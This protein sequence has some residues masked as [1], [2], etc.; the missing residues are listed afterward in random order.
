LNN[1]ENNSAC[2]YWEQIDIPELGLSWARRLPGFD[3]GA[4]LYLCLF[5]Y[6]YGF[7]W[8]T[9]EPE[10]LFRGGGQAVLPNGG[11][12]VRLPLGDFAVVANIDY[13]HLNELLHCVIPILP[14]LT[15]P[16]RTRTRNSVEAR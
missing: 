2:N 12:G 3:I 7:R 13:F 8:L 16:I 10:P 5:Q 6:E 14:I 11:A 9:P 15:T 4:H 1:I